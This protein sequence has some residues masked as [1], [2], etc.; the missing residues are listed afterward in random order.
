MEQIESQVQ[1]IMEEKIEENTIVINNRLKQLI[2]NMILLSIFL[3]IILY[4][5]L[6]L[7]MKY[8]HISKRLL[9]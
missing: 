7:L 1:I 5:V 4:V 9:K 8:S 6:D 3:F 2:I